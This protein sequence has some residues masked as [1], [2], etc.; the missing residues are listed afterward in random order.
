VTDTSSD[1][2]KNVAVG[3]SRLWPYSP[4]RIRGWAEHP[5]GFV[6]GLLR[7]V[8]SAQPAVVFTSLAALCVPTFSDECRIVID[9]DD[10]ARYLII[11]PLGAADNS[12]AAVS[13]ERSAAATG[14]QLLSGQT[15]RTP[16]LALSSTGEFDYRGVVTHYWRDDHPTP[17]DAALAQLAVDRA[18]A[19]VHRERLHARLV[20]QHRTTVN[21]SRA[22]SRA[23]STR[24]SGFSASPAAVSRTE[25]RDE[26]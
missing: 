16:F 12:L 3:H 7:L 4:L 5:S 9:E 26:H 20:H 11:R 6:S 24:R 19:T 22:R 13:G 1:T 10:C 17:V 18:V 15:V 2:M 14:P 21:E 23:A 25:R 8:A